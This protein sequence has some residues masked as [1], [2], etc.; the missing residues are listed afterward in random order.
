MALPDQTSC[1]LCFRTL[2]H[3]GE[4]HFCPHQQL[5]GMSECQAC[6]QLTRQRGSTAALDAEPE[7]L[8][9]HPPDVVLA[10]PQSHRLAYSDLS[11]SGIQRG[12]HDLH[13]W[14]GG[15][16]VIGHRYDHVYESDDA[17]PALLEMQVLIP[18][19]GSARA[20]VRVSAPTLF[21]RLIVS[22]P[23]SLAWVVVLEARVGNRSMFSAQSPSPAS[24]TPISTLVLFDKWDELFGPVQT[25][26]DVTFQLG[27]DSLKPINFR[28]VWEVVELRIRDDGF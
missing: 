8:A 11:S 24:G 13:P 17:K 22:E 28:C 16:P 10:Q 19:S 9:T 7:A 3:A 14:A 2:R 25:A 21:R 6:Q 27:N 12:S 18:P 15:N 1:E 4:R 26:V 20:Y 23:D 5:C